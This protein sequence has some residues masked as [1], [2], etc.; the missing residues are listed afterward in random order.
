LALTCVAALAVLP[1]A[2]AHADEQHV[3]LVNEARGFVHDSIPAATAFIRRLGERSPRYDVVY[4]ERGAAQLTRR[5]LRG[6]DAVL[7]AN[8]SG[9]LPL[10]ARSALIRFVRRGGGFLGTHSATDTLHSWPGFKRLIG[11]EFAR[12]GAVQ[13]GRLI[14]ARR[15]SSITRGLPRSV[16]L[17]DEFYE[18]T[19]P[20][21]RHTRVLLRLDPESVPDELGRELPLVWMRRLGTGRVFYDAL[22]HLPETWATDVQ[23]R[24]V[25][26]G[27]AWVLR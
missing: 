8:T 17:E 23:R 5:R 15:T 12:H 4:L 27:I 3:L 26:R 24:L 22:G 21:P 10:P 20:L 7:F 6:A 14:V 13:E 18:F 9:E 2:T 16:R 19:D 25:A 1:A 11:A